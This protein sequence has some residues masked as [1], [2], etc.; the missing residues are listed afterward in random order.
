MQYGIMILALSY[1]ISGVYGMESQSAIASAE[2]HVDAYC[3]CSGIKKIEK[4]F[5]VCAASQR[6]L[7]AP[8]LKWNKDEEIN[9]FLQNTIEGLALILRKTQWLKIITVK[10]PWGEYEIASGW[11]DAPECIALWNDFIA[12][13]RSRVQLRARNKTDIYEWYDIGMVDEQAFPEVTFGSM[14][15]RN[16]VKDTSYEESLN[17]QQGWTMLINKYHQI[18]NNQE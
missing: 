5:Q 11:N 17:I 4:M 10:C 18:S 15:H 8:Q 16:Y 12:N 3:Y 9:P 7:N 13:T 14:G 1:I 6:T 2:A